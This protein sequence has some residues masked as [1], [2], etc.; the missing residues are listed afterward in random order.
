MKKLYFLHVRNIMIEQYG[1]KWKEST[2]FMIYL[3]KKGMTRE[4][5]IVYFYLNNTANNKII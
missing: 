2:Q 4:S 3:E 5:L 1:R